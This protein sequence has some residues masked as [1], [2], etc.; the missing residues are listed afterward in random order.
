[1]AAVSSSAFLVAAF[2]R[3]FFSLYRVSGGRW[4]VKGVNTRIV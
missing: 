2:Q 1:M 3:F 4:Q